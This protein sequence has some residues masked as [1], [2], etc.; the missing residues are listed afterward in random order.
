MEKRVALVMAVLGVLAGGVAAAQSGRP[1]F[2]IGD[3][4]NADGSPVRGHLPAGDHTGGRGFDVRPIRKDGQ[5]LG[6][7]WQDA[8]YDREMTQ[9]LVDTFLQTGGVGR[10]IFGDPQIRGVVHYRGFDDHLHVTT[11]PHFKRQPGR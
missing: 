6:V 7:R 2:Q 11:D 4:G 9:R 5:M 3:I 8:A 10:I 1:P